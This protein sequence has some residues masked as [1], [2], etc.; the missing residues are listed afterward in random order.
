MVSIF[1]FFFNL[2]SSNVLF[3]P[4]RLPRHFAR[5]DLNLIP[6]VLKHGANFLNLRLM[7]ATLALIRLENNCLTNLRKERCRFTLLCIVFIYGQ[8]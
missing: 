2:Y 8:A 5:H 6:D 3:A 7:I 4:L 1:A